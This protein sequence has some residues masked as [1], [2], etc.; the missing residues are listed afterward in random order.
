VSEEQVVRFSWEGF[1]VS[2]EDADEA[3]F[4]VQEAGGEVSIPP[5]A[6]P[7]IAF[8]PIVVGA[9]ALVGLAKAIKSFVDDLGKGVVVDARQEPLKITKDASLPRGIV[10]VVGKDGSVKLEQPDHESLKS[11]IEATLSAVA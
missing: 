5:P 9:I 8:I 10:V 1:E 6:E 2:D 7:G 11:L 4:R 3:A